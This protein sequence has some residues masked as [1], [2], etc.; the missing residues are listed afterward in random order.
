MWPQS[1]HQ[2]CFYRRSFKNVTAATASKMLPRSSLFEDYDL[3]HRLMDVTAVTVSRM[4]P[5]SPFQKGYRVHRFYIESR[6]LPQKYDRRHRFVDVAT[7]TVSRM[8]PLSP[9]QECYRMRRPSRAASRPRSLFQECDRSHHL[10][11]VTAVTV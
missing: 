6:M 2:E 1:P 10:M 3:S 5:Q 9:L 4:S 7:V 11:N 8:S